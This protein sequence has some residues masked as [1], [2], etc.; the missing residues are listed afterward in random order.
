M[1]RRYFRYQIN[2]ILHGYK[3]TSKSYIKHMESIGV[4][5]GKDIRLFSPID[6][7]IDLQNPWLLSFGDN[8]RITKGVKILTH[9]YSWSVLSEIEGNI[10]GSVGPVKIGNNVFI[11]M[12][13]I[14]LKDTIIGD[15]VIIG[16]GSVIKGNIES[17][18]VYVGNPAKKIMTI[19]KFYEIRKERQLNEAINIMKSYEECFDSKPNEKI[20]R[21][22]FFL[23]KIRN[24]ELEEEYKQLM[25]KTGYVDKVNRYYKN[26]NPKFDGFE[27]FLEHYNKN[28]SNINR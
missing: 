6:T 9:D 11:G 18:S 16:A 21:E 22:Y 19:D 28:F 26:S 23:Y 15:N 2:K 4:K 7:H 5:I 14:I 3:A 8:V 27:D 13:A 25:N 17:N 10:C 20:L 12:N 24:N 1:I